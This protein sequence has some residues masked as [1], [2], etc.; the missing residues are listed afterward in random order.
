MSVCVRPARRLFQKVIKVD[1]WLTGCEYGDRDVSYCSQ[2]PRVDCYD[3][4]IQKTCCV[5]C[6]AERDS[7]A[8]ADCQFGDKASWCHPSQL[9]PHSCYSSAS[10][11]CETCATYHTGPPG[12]PLHVRF[13]HS[14]QAFCETVVEMH[15]CFLLS[16]HDYLYLPYLPCSPQSPAVWTNSEKYRQTG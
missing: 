16:V 4:N 10:T 15:A 14:A 2:I 12:K 1:V 3:S 7:D 9:E 13:H 6:A 11:C 8:P 5:R